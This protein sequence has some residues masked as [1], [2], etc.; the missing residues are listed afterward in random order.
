MSEC[1][2]YLLI[3]LPFLKKPLYFEQYCSLLLFSRWNPFFPKSND[4][5]LFQNLFSPYSKAWW[6]MLVGRMCIKENRDLNKGWHRNWVFFKC[7][8]LCSEW[9]DSFLSN[10]AIKI[11]MT[12][13][14]LYLNTFEQKDDFVS[15]GL[16]T[17]SHL[18][19][20][21]CACG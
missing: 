5:F 4:E 15:N 14:T 19:G 3:H 13:W 6:V 7:S 21:M 8:L 17:I 18:L 1:S 16:L 12:S 10:C 9:N 11:K 20:C 2:S